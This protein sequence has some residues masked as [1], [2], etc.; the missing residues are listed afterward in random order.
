[1]DSERFQE[2]VIGHLVHITQEITD[3][4]TDIGVLKTDVGVLKTDYSTLKGSI[5]SIK[6]QTAL[7]TEFKNETSTKFEKVMDYMDYFKVHFVEVDT[8]LLRLKK[9]IS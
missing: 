9:K 7:L 1:M 5:E 6:E 8:E 4:K 3:M 2:I